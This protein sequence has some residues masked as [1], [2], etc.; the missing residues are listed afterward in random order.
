[1]QMINKLEESN[2]LLFIQG[3]HH[4][5]YVIKSM[6]EKRKGKIP[7]NYELFREGQKNWWNSLSDEEKQKQ[8]NKISD[9][10]KGRSSPNKGKKMSEEQKQKISKSLKGNVPW[11][12]RLMNNREHP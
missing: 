6:S 3:K 9:S 12:K 2:G 7:G 4:K 8:R 1:M 11:N 10:C 5:Q